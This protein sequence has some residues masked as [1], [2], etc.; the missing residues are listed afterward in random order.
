MEN[1]KKNGLVLYS[2][3]N[4][5]LVLLLLLVVQAV[6]IRGKD[7]ETL[8]AGTL[9]ITTCMVKKVALGITKM[10]SNGI[11][12][13][14]QIMTI[15]AT[16]HMEVGPEEKTM[17]VLEIKVEIVVPRGEAVVV[18]VAQEEVWV[19]VVLLNEEHTQTTYRIRKNRFHVTVSN[20]I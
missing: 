7:F 1:K 5:I 17:E 13:L 20:T 6:Q 4:V 12:I 2:S 19:E 18:D 8:E 15:L 16:L 10:K 9:M 3:A 14:D 11:K